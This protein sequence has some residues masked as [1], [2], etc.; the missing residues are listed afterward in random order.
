MDAV[1]LLCPSQYVLLRV[2]VIVLEMLFL[3]FISMDLM[4]QLGLGFFISTS[5]LLKVVV[6]LHKLIPIVHPCILFKCQTLANAIFSFFFS[7][8]LKFS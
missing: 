1:N 8:I 6:V 4:L 5:L 2:D 7:N 3:F